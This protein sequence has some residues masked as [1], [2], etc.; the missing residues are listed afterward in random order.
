V[1]DR[2]VSVG[3]ELKASGFKAEATA[4]EEKVEALDRKVDALDRSITKIP[5]DAAKA[6]AAMKLLGDESGRAGGKLDE[7]G[8]RTTRLQEVDQRIVKTRG[9]V[10]ALAEEFNRTGD[11]NV[12]ERMFGS[13]RELKELESLKKRITSQGWATPGQRAARSSPRTSPLRRRVRPARR[14]SVPR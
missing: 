3:L 1:A 4:A 7:F 8:Q 11:V 14:A 12:L 2:K 5:P 9:E 6:A 13:Q 10:R